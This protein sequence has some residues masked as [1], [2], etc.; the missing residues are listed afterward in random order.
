MKDNPENDGIKTI[1]ISALVYDGGVSGIAEYT[2]SLIN[3]LLKEHKVCITLLKKDYKDFPIKSDHLKVIQ[4][5]NIF[6]AP[7]LN[8]FWHIVVLPILLL[9]LRIDFVILP[10]INRR[11]ALW[12]GKPT[13][14]IIHDLSQYA[15]DG[16]YDIFRTFYVKYI[17]PVMA[18]SLNM[19]L[20]ISENTKSDV[21]K[22]WHIDSKKIEVCYN[23][24]N[25]TLFGQTPPNNT[26]EVIS[27]LGIDSEYLIYTSRIEHP[28]KNHI[29]LIKAYEK[30]PDK[31]KQSHKLVFTGSD[32]TGAEHVRSY[33]KQS[34][35]YN[36][37]IFLGYVQTSDL[38]ALYHRASAS[39]L[40]SLYEG[41]GIPLVEAMACGTATLCSNNSALNEV[42]GNASLTFNPNSSDDIATKIKLVLTNHELKK[43]IIT[44]GLSRSKDFDWDVLG[45]TISKIFRTHSNK[46]L[47]NSKP[48]FGK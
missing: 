35:D 9:F 34:D 42:A 23:G 37:I 18:S 44:K 5:A 29:N 19:V 31:I 2:R 47:N 1:F 33:A 24:F 36:R 4:V 32:W 28:G 8:I 21:I 15:I 41:F 6:D 12:V 17:L 30:L 43:E 25:K 46:Q 20:A 13:L 26:L 16:K 39:I 45:K 27:R 14:G 40:P 22:Y 7:L 11:M 38:P 48:T 10:A 3:S